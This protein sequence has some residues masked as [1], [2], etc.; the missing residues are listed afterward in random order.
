MPRVWNSRGGKKM[1]VIL[2]TIKG[3]EKTRTE[4]P[5]WLDATNDGSAIKREDKDTTVAVF[6]KGGD[7]DFE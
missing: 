7:F 1:I 4:Y 5:N 6:L 2:Q 3:K